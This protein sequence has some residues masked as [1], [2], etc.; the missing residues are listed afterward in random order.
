MHSTKTSPE[1][2]VPAWDSTKT[3]PEEMASK[4]DSVEQ[5]AVAEPVNDDIPDV[6]IFYQLEASTYGA[7]MLLPCKT[8]GKHVFGWWDFISV[9][10][11]TALAMLMQVVFILV[12]GYNMLD[13]PYSKEKVAT[14][15]QWRAT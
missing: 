13:N 5:E 1:E 14:M 2:M 10:V 11:S 3:V 7:L 15:A 9:L 4:M 12:I 8:N 6:Q